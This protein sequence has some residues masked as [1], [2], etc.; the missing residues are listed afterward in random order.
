MQKCP[1]CG[2]DLVVKHKGQNSFLACSG[3][4]QC[5]FTRGLREQ[6]EIEPEGLDVPCPQCG[7][8]LQ[9]K[10]GRY[11]LFVGCSDFPDC[12]FVTEPDTA[13]AEQGV[14][15]PECLKHGR[16]GQL[17]QKTSRRGS[18]FFACDQYP[19]CD[20]SVNLPP[21]SKSC[22]VCQFPLLLRK[23]QSGLV[24]HICPQKSCEY[25]SEPL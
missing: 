10:S 3:F 19:T 1:Q 24:R 23:K 21:V 8:E 16:K 25:K 12:D 4:P 15:C 7:Q 22:P 9:L 11:G 6:S 20:F 5:D 13:T 14:A 17:I 2:K 18:S